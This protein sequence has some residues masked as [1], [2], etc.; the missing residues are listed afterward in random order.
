MGEGKHLRFRVRQNGRDGGRAIAFGR[1]S[2]LGALQDGGRFDV[3]FQLT[4]NHWNGTVSP[5][6]VIRRIFVAAAGYDELRGSLV[7]LWRD[8]EGAWTPQA[9]AIFAE[10]ALAEAKG[11]RQL[12]ESPTF[13]ALLDEGAPVE[14]RQAA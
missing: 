1:G 14:L 9:R 5:Q 13:R 4:E 10:L 2:Q 3:A 6:L 12:L 11:G 8:G 7:D